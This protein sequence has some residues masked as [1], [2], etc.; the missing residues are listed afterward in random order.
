MSVS[1]VRSSGFSG[2][3]VGMLVAAGCAA[4]P[5]VEPGSVGASPEDE[6]SAIIRSALLAATSIWTATSRT[7]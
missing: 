5:P 6:E 7:W 1:R 4:D 2:L 3:L